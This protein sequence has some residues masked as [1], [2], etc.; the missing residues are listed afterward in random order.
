M[1]VYNFAMFFVQSYIII[2]FINVT[3]PVC[4]C[5]VILLFISAVVLLMERDEYNAEYFVHKIITDCA[6]C[7]LVIICN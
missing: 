2:C 7:A 1:T 5:I 3:N 4:L 6:L